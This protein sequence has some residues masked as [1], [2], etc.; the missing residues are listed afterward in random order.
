MVSLDSGSTAPGSEPVYS[1]KEICSKLDAFLEK[2][3]VEAEKK[4]NN[5]FDAAQSNTARENLLLSLR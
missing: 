4:L 1:S 3:D 5:L 2:R